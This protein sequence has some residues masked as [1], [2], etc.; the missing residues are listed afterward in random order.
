[1]SQCNNINYT[2]IAVLVFLVGFVYY[3]LMPFQ[4][5]FTGKINEKI[6]PYFRKI[7][8]TK[9]NLVDT[10]STRVYNIYRRYL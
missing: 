2:E 3:I 9:D 1:M 10:I 4:E 8:R 7:R 5:G 6:N